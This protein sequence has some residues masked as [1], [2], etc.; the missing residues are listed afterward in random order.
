MNLKEY[1]EQERGNATRLA[2]A[3][4][5]QLSYL[6]QMAS[7]IRPINPVRAVQIERVT[8]GAVKRKDM[9]PEDWRLFWPELA[10][11]RD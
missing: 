10:K 5:V 7:G 6:S 4:G 2:A 11:K 3:M 1:L 8:R 9:F